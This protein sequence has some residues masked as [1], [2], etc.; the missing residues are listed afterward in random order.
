MRWGVRGVAE[1]GEGE[2]SSGETVASGEVSEE[3]E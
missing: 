3:S 2:G 1:S